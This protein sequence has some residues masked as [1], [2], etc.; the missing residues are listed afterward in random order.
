MV[1]EQGVDS[2]VMLTSFVEGEKNK[3]A[4][5]FPKYKQFSDYDD[6]QVECKQELSFTNY[7][8]RILYVSVQNEEIQVTHYHFLKWMDHDCPRTPEDL[9]KFVKIVR[10]ERKNISNPL[11]VHCSAGVGRT[12]TFI[13]L[14][15]LMQMIKQEKRL[16]IY[17]VVKHLRIQ[18]MKMVQTLGQYV[19]LYKCVYE[20]IS[21]EKD[22]KQRL[23]GN[24]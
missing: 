21:K 13:A 3:C 2:I 23:K 24:F 12:G 11:V 1:Y 15:I 16:N 5:Y 4:E 7:K 14:D 6:I 18:R 20:I 8:K 19:F 22:W 9:I 10:N 17:E